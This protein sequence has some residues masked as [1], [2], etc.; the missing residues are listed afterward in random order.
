MNFFNFLL[1]ASPAVDTSA[2]APTSWQSLT[3]FAI[4][5]LL[6]VVVFY[7][8]LYRPQKKQEKEVREMRSSIAVGD[9]ISTSGGIVGVV[10]KIKDDM[11]LI[12]SGADRTKLQIQKWAVHSVLS[13]AGEEKSE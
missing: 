10:I 1:E 7:F 3:S 9:V 2:P 4:P 11:I 5:I 6:L 12:E 13:K 8:F